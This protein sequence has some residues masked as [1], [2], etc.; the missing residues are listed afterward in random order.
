LFE[1]SIVSRLTALRQDHVDYHIVVEPRPEGPVI[2]Y[3][4]GQPIAASVVDYFGRRFVYEGVAPRR[5]NGQY[6]IESLRPGEWIVEPGLV[7]QFDMNQP[8]RGAN[9]FSRRQQREMGQP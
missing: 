7:Y 6:D 9:K 1:G 4:A 3:F 5:R 8:K 2:G